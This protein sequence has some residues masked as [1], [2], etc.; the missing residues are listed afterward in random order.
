[1]T[2]PATLPDM[3]WSEFFVDFMEALISPTVLVALIAAVAAYLSARAAFA[4]VT[5]KRRLETAQRFTDLA[6]VAN[7]VDGRGGAYEQIA[8]IWL[9]GSFG[10]DERH[11]RDA[12]RGT[13]D[14]I[15]AWNEASATQKVTRVT[16]AANG[17]RALLS[18][19]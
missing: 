13:L 14:S 12:A 7:N 1:M 10:R 16:T 3:D 5:L 15:A 18:K 19:K 8:A 6:K 2:R 4:D 17:A 9:L 11:L